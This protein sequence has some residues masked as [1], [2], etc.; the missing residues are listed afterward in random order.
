MW[1]GKSSTCSV[2]SNGEDMKGKPIKNM[3]KLAWE[4]LDWAG[5][6]AGKIKVWSVVVILFKTT[7]Q[8]GISLIYLFATES[9]MSNILSG[10]D[11]QRLWKSTLRGT[12][13][14]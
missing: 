13:R 7:Q 4:K 14:S 10:H 6:G 8:T 3:A 12:A 9:G 2:W 11:V 5:E 1:F